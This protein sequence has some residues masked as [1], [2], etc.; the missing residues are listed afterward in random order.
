MLVQDCPDIADD[1][2]LVTPST[3]KLDLEHLLRDL[4]KYRP[5][6]SPHSWE[7]WEEFMANIDDLHLEHPDLDVNK[8]NLRNLLSAAILTLTPPL[9]S[10]TVA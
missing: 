7:E 6:L 10:D 8:W 4:P 1:P 3:D 5:R 9:S 2:S